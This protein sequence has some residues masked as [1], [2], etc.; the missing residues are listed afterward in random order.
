LDNYR[1]FATGPEIGRL[2][3]NT[4]IWLT[5]ISVVVR[6]LLG[7]CIAMLFNSPALKRLRLDTV[8]RIAILV[9]W[10]TPPIVAV[11]IW[12]W[13]LDPQNGIVNR[14]LLALGLV[15]DPVAFLS[16]LR[17]VWP[18]VITIIVWNTVPLVALSLLAAL[19]AVPADL[20]EAADLDGASRWVKFRYIT[21]PFLKPTIMVLGLTSVFWT[22][23]NFVYVWLATGA[24]PGTFTNVLATETYIRAF[25]DFRLGY[26]AAI[27]VC[28][29]LIMAAFGGLYFRVL[30]RRQIEE[31]L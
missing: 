31:V 18:S 8:A 24:G 29:A 15:S 20:Y 19:Q 10:A 9:P 22:F 5:A 6:L 7:L 21:L 25:V 11:I 14:G 26:S 27:G 23:N 1:E 13:M 2:M 4:F 3:F 30:G 12:R 28:M 16:D 17:T